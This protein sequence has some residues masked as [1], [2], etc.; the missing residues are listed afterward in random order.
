MI[1]KNIHT[2]WHDLPDG[3]KS[4]ET[5]WDV[6]F[7]VLGCLIYQSAH[8]SLRSFYFNYFFLKNEIQNPKKHFFQILN[9]SNILKCVSMLGFSSSKYSSQVAVP[10][11]VSYFFNNSPNICAAWAVNFRSHPWFFHWKAV[12]KRWT[13]RD[14]KQ[15]NNKEELIDKMTYHFYCSEKGTPKLLIQHVNLCGAEMN[16]MIC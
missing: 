1:L 14:S 15:K 5:F 8:H 3:F 9:E 4:W 12:P 13:W 7:K 11:S 2:S 16:L 10:T 6:S